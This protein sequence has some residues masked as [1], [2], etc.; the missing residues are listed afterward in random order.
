M[1]TE[2]KQFTKAAGIIGLFTLISRI[3]GFV[4]DMV[5]AWFFGA[6][7]LTDAFFVAFRLPNLFRRLF[8]EGSLTISFIPVFSRH[9]SAHGK[10][11]AFQMARSAVRMLSVI[12]AAITLA[13]I[14]AA[15]A[16]VS[17]IAPGFTG[18][19]FSMTVLLTRIMFPYI[20]FICIVALS[21]GILN[22]LGHFAAPA[23]APVILNL[24]IIASVLFISPMLSEPVVG[25]AVGVVIGG[26]LQLLLQLPFLVKNGF[27]FWRKANIYHPGLKS[28]GRLMLPSVFGAAVYQINILIGTLLASFLAAGS[29]SY[30]YYADRLVQFPLGLFAISMSVAILPSL[31]R[32]AAARDMKG[33]NDTFAYAIKLIFFITLPAM[34]GLIILRRPI[35][36]LLFER[37]AFDPVSSALTA[38]ALLYFSIGLW[39]FSAVRIVVPT[40]YALQDT[41]TPVITGIVSVF[42]NIILCL[43]LMGPLAHAGLA[44][45]ASLSSMLNFILLILALNRKIGDPGWKKI[46]E[47]VAKSVVCTAIMGICLQAFVFFHPAGANPAGLNHS[48][49]ASS[50]LS[51]MWMVCAGVAIGIFVYALAAYLLKSRELKDLIVMFKKG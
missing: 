34:T 16:I 6:G 20:F 27:Y 29:V 39:A 37:G 17:V 7:P 14:I 5:I 24:S 2:K 9:I 45:S 8:G 51:L 32:Q 21:M 25:L 40:F 46:I 4:R 49:A 31:S 11:A 43:L 26:I 23:L 13:G 38:D 36:S 35:V 44:L 28:I 18:T 33:L 42:A 22:A 15:P 50:G 41:R 12:L 1:P 3:L 30:L 48:R 10:E 19:Q 47:S